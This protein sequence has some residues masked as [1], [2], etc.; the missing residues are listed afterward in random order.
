MAA[1]MH[2]SKTSKPAI[3]VLRIALI[4]LCL[5]TT[6]AY[7]ICKY[8]DTGSYLILN[9]GW[10]AGG[11][12][13]NEVYV[14]VSGFTIPIVI[15]D[16]VYT[17]VSSITGSPPLYSTATVGKYTF[18]RST[19]QSPSNHTTNYAF[20]VCSSP[21]FDGVLTTEKIPGYM[22]A[23]APPNVIINGVVTQVIPSSTNR[24]QAVAPIAIVNGEIYRANFSDGT[25]SYLKSPNTAPAVANRSAS[26][27]ED[28]STSITLTATD[29]DAGDS[30]TFALVSSPGAGSASI[31]GNK[32]TYTPPANWNGQTTL[33]YRATDSKGAISNTATV[34]FT[35]TAVNDAP[36][37]TDRTMTTPEDTAGQITL[38]VTDVDLSYEG[39]SHTWEIVSPPNAAHGSA[40]ISGAILRFTPAANWYGMT[41]L[42]YRVRDSKGAV[43]GTQKVTITVSAVNDAP[44]VAARSM[45]MAEDTSSTI[46]LSATDIDS[47]TP[48]KFEVVAQ[49]S[50]GAGAGTIVGTSL[51]FKPAADWNGTT[52]LTYRAQDSS[53]AWS[54]PATV[55][56]T[57]NPVND[58]PTPGATLEFKVLEGMPQTIKIKVIP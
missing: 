19:Q 57:V 21:N 15:Q 53:G 41:T 20:T 9:D 16:K 55:S 35:V 50:G 4:W 40:T 45:T 3:T 29:P 48:T 11:Y 6:Q 42:T 18:T 56:I 5:A 22:E 10:S 34:T 46:T 14:T 8:S 17:H 1:S 31:S 24:P 2:I 58:A 49:P 12:F 43:S 47:P 27:Q 28:S 13:Y 39:D 7:A 38:T 36:S 51:S 52:S 30:H 54:S 25:I 44:V 33:K 32:L 26:L 23:L 37:T